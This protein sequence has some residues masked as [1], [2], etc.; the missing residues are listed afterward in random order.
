MGTGKLLGKPNN[1][2]RNELPWTSILSRGI[3]NTPSHFMLQKQGIS[4]GSYEPVGSK[5]S[6]SPVRRSR[7]HYPSFLLS[8]AMKFASKGFKILLPLEKY[9][10]RP[11]AIG[12]P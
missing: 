5:A 7:F 6:F 8:A 10:N 4:S 3:R 11:C 12:C 2:V 9:C 1:L